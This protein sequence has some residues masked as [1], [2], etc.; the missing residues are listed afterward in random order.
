MKTTIFEWMQQR[1]K[2]QDTASRKA[3]W[4]AWN[5]LQKEISAA[6]LKNHQCL[7]TRFISA[8]KFTSPIKHHTTRS[9]P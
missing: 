4:S 1:G 9:L 7:N 5:K 8:T 6:L 3:D 2:W